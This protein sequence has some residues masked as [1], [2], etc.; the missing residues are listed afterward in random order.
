[1]F[2]KVNP[3]QSFPKLE[4]EILN[5]W[6]ENDTFKKSINTRDNA[7]EFNFYDGPPFA[8][9][10]PHYGHILAGTIK[11]VI[12]RYQTMKGKKVE[13]NFG[14]DCH[15]LPIENIVEKKL[16]ISGKDDIENKIGVYQFNETCRAN[17]F[18]Y[19][20]EWK[21]TVDRMG[22]WVDMENDYKT[23]D[24]SFMESVWRVFKNIYDKGLI[25]EGNRVVPYCPRCTTPLSNFEVNQGYK[26]KQS[27]TVTVKF[28][29]KSDKQDICYKESTGIIVRNE[30]GKILFGKRKTNGLLTLAGGKIELGET[31]INCA[32]RELEEETGIKS[33]KLELYTCNYSKHNN[34]NWKEYVYILDVKND[35]TFGNPEKNKFENWK[36]YDLNELKNEEVES[37]DHQI[38]AQLK[39]EKE[40]NKFHTNG[41]KYILAWTT[42]PWTLYANLGLAVGSDIDYVELLD[43]TNGDTY[44]LAKEKVKDYYKK[45]EDYNIVREYKG[46]CLVGIKYEPIFDDFDLQIN[47][48]G[49]D[50]GPGI[51][52]G[53]NAWSIVLGHHV[54][55]TDGTGIVH[56]APAYGEDDFII[57]EKEDLG[58]VAHIDNSGKTYNLLDNNGKF[59]FDFNEMVI[60]ELKEK[61]L[62]INIGTIVHSYPHCWRC[63]TPLIYRGIS[64]WYVAVEK[65]RDKMVANNQKITWV[66]EV[67]KDGRFGKWLEQARDWNIS[68]NRYWGSALPIWQSED[69]KEE[70]CVGSIEELYEKN[71]DFGQIT[72]VL[73]VRHRESEK[74]VLGIE[75]CV[76]P[77]KYSLSEKGK[78][79][80]L[81]LAEILKNEKIDVIFSSPFKRCLQTVETISKNSGKEINIDERLREINVGKY[82]GK[83]IN[84]EN[85]FNNEKIGET[86]ESQVECY[87]RIKDFMT[88]IVSENKGKTILICSH[89]DPLLLAK[90]VIKDFDFDNKNIRKEM[91]P[92][93]EN[94]DVAYV[95]SNTLQEVDLHKHF[96]DELL[97][98]N[99]KNL[100]AKNVL[101]VHGFKR[102][103]ETLVDFFE[104]TKK[105][106][107]KEGVKM[108]APTFEEGA[109]VSYKNWA[110]K[111]DEIN[112]K[113]YDTI[114]AHSM[115]CRAS[116]EYIAEHKIK[117]DRLVLVA[118]AIKGSGKPEITKFYSEMTHEFSEIKNLVKEI[119]VLTS[120][121]DTV[122]R[123]DE[124]EELAKILNANLIYVNGYGHFNLHECNLIE[125]IVKNGS[126]L[127]RIPEV[128][129]CW[130][131]S[132]AMPYASRHYPFENKENFRFPADFIA[133]GLDQTRGWFYTLI[134]LS[135]ALFDS[136]ATLNTIVN[137]IVLAEDGKKMSKSLKNYPDPQKIFDNYGADA[138]RFYLMNSPVVE[139]QDLRFSETGVEEV[140]KK[141]ILPLW[142]TYSF[143]TTYA[144]IDKFEPKKGNIYYC[145]HGKTNDNNTLKMSGGE[146]DTQLNEIGLE[147]ATKAGKNFKLSKEKI[148]IIISSPLKRAKK[149]AEIIAKENGF[150][151]DIIEDDRLIE[152]K[153]GIFSGMTHEEIRN[154]AKK[155]LNIELVEIEQTRKFFKDVKYNKA[156]DIKLFDE[157]VTSLV[158]EI[159][160]KF[161]GKN[162]LIVAHSGTYRP[163][164]RY[165]N[166]ID[167]EEANFNLP[168]IPNA[169]IFKMPTSRENILDKWIISELNKLILEVST[170]LDSYKINEA[171]RPIVLFM[172]NL[173]NWYIRRSRKR[174]WKENFDNDKTEA[175]ETLYEV[176]I[177]LSKILAPF[178]PFVSEYIY[179]NLTGKE[180]V[181]LDIFPTANKSF[182]LDNLNSSFDKTAKIINLGLACRE[183]NRLRV[184]QPLKSIKISEVLD[185]YYLDIIK[186]ELNIKEVLYFSESEM[187]KKICKPNARLI[188][189]KFG[190]DVKFIIAEAKVG[191]FEELEGGK[192]KVGD[193]VLEEGEYEIAYEKSELIGDL[194]SG[195]GMVVSLDT[196]LSEALIQEGFARDLIRHIQESRKEANFNVDDRIQI[197]INGGDKIK[198]ITNN[199]K[200]YI[201]TETLSTIVENLEKS[202]FEKEI[203]LEEYKI[204]LSLKK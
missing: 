92:S 131:E 56:I 16:E 146:V 174:F 197:S 89:G 96:V 113:N 55:T 59:V 191:N 26:D 69:K 133:E 168:S 111:F 104:G 127:K 19:V 15:G 125:S 158:K 38:I 172:D 163:I 126:P 44:I 5:Y 108:F 182:I 105:N 11:D 196:N 149:T 204:K 82:D 101:G 130:F 54:T 117:L 36:F 102:N 77:N 41:N 171:A 119:I 148:D 76:D 48:M 165:I 40:I 27:K 10:T 193:F 156:E 60:G 151:G 128:L 21:K 80:A 71:K 31:P 93:K 63:D 178:M 81:N 32:K 79:E 188:G 169:T 97:I 2:Q 8:T 51:C 195:F 194:E 145:R 90:K 98:K 141:V 106:L 47:E 29:V 170:N 202:D 23:M 22:R 72:K 25:Y 1:M 70:I 33:D 159:K 144:N 14:W 116:I 112:L 24:T 35:V 109:N 120:K 162:V 129:D 143:F 61:K 91:Y 175:Y 184:R 189:P 13:R 88:Q 201:Q 58:F 192:V 180:S 114:L 37:Y 138:M 66:P 100:K 42:T 68:R 200:E 46:A 30:D 154:Y 12:P 135:T 4:E 122:V 3:K 121:D 183:R 18:G 99:E 150:N 147:Q 136:P 160:E 164:N 173:T 43:K 78:Q 139:A 153:A 134:I 103:P 107:E 20:D 73:L 203:E 186:D 115:G 140:V 62:S 6:K 187:P 7:E 161:H 86:G 137:G 185:D 65:I 155:E 84:W 52:L 67:I 167:F 110:K 181:H 49:K 152:L 176:L 157:R 199:F 53:K 85:K 124:A 75:D 177:E 34:E 132:G 64:A 50:L 28:K 94:F 95:Y 74:N 166:N 118:P 9:G 190:G 57:G 17:V 198:S 123:N 179:K 83:A 142:N 87:D 45:E 39:G